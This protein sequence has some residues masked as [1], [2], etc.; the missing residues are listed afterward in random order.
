[1]ASRQ[2]CQIFSASSRFPARSRKSAYRMDGR[3]F[4]IPTRK[5]IRRARS[6]RLVPIG[7]LLRQF[8]QSFQFLDGI[9]A[10][11][12]YRGLQNAQGLFFVAFG[13]EE[14]RQALLPKTLVRGGSGPTVDSRPPVRRDIVLDSKGTR[15]IQQFLARWSASFGGAGL[16]EKIQ[17]S[18]EELQ[19]R[20]SVQDWRAERPPSIRWSDSVRALPGFKCLEPVSAHLLG[21]RHVGD[22]LPILGLMRQGLENS[23]C[24]FRIAAIEFEMTNASLDLRVALGR[25]F[26]QALKGIDR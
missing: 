1:M 15:F 9:F 13:S 18:G 14:R 17:S 25:E 4:C 3:A 24:V 21:Q 11:P 23:Q 5:T 8:Y 19:A 16:F 10:F 2:S 12:R 7:R 20:R 6:S 22:S 26:G